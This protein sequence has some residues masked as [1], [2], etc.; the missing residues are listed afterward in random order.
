M[1]INTIRNQVE[2]V[3]IENP[4]TRDDDKLLTVAVWQKFYL[5]PGRSF[6]YLHEIHDL[7]SHDAIKRIRA[8][9]QNVERRLVP[10]SPEVAKSR[11]M[12]ETVWENAMRRDL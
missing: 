6:V 2:R 3:L 4:K 11:R 12:A 9:I 8:K 1:G 5:D 7:P 10:T